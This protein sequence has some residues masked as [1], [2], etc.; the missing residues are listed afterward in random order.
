MSPAIKLAVT[1]PS[2]V[3]VLPGSSHLYKQHMFDA[4]PSYD[5]TSFDD[6]SSPAVASSSSIA[7][8]T[9]LRA[10]ITLTVPSD[11]QAE[12]VL[13]ALTANLKAYQSLA[14]NNGAFQQSHP[15]DLRVSV[16]LPPHPL[17]L[18]N[19][20]RSPVLIIFPPSVQ[21]ADA[22]L[23]YKLSVRAKTVPATYSHSKLAS[24]M[25]ITTLTDSVDL[26]VVQAVEPEAT[27]S[28]H[29]NIKHVSIERL[30]AVCISTTPPSPCII[31]ASTTVHLSLPDAPARASSIASVELHLTQHS[32]IR[33][34]PNSACKISK[35]EHKPRLVFPLPAVARP[36]QRIQTPAS[37]ARAHLQEPKT[38]TAT[39]SYQAG[40]HI[41]LCTDLQAST[42]SGTSTAIHT[43]HHL[44]LVIHF[45]DPSNQPRSFESCWPITLAHS[46]ATSQDPSDHLPTYAAA[47]PLRL[48]NADAPT[49]AS[50][51]ALVRPIP[52]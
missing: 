30:G 2:P 27:H 48:S 36:R 39:D 6:G 33:W 18:N 7:S 3:L 49:S 40:F 26:T 42:L 28:Y 52:V 32:S 43:S 15:V 35:V 11:Q 50:A 31:G 16:P 23:R 10:L 13:T 47:D 45:F 46:E 25:R 19:K 41:P 22:R 37:S 51:S 8:H 20:Q 4:P 12:H 29:S 21:L 17:S 14:H 24:L 1:L 44:G 9:I 34:R 5:A 38:T